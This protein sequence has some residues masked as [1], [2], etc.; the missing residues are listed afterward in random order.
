MHEQSIVESLLSLALKNAEQNQAERILA[1]N[2]V[3]GDLTGVVEDAVNFY[4]NFLARET[5]A[6]GATIKYRR[7]PVKMRCRDCR[8][9]FEP[10]RLDMKCPGCGGQN[11]D[12]IA[13]R[14]LFVE[15]LEV[16]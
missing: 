6:A 7:V 3:V 12:I 1:I 5:I 11:V 14:E 15:S 9:V 4:F 16:V 8:Q 2:V 13:G 10:E